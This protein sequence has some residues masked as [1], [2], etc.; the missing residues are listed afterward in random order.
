MAYC[1]GQR[2][3]IQNNTQNAVLELFRALVPMDGHVEQSLKRVIHFS[4]D[5]YN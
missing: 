5:C 2:M 1:E 3:K 4:I